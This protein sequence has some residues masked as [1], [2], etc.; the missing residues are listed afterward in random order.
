VEDLRVTSPPGSGPA[1]QMPPRGKAPLV[2]GGV[3][4]AMAVV[5]AL[6]VLGPDGGG[7]ASGDTDR[8]S[9]AGAQENE[10]GPED[11]VRRYVGAD[12]CQSLADATTQAYQAEYVELSG[13]RST[14]DFV[15]LC[16]QAREG[17]STIAQPGEVGTVEVVTQGRETA[18]VQ[19]TFLV[20]GE[21]TSLELPLRIEGGRWRVDA[22]GIDSE[23][24][25]TEP[26]GSAPS[27]PV[28][29]N[30]RALVDAFL[31]A[32]NGGDADAAAAMV[33]PNAGEGIPSGITD[34]V[35]GDASLEIDET[36]ATESSVS[37]GADL[38]GTV[39][40]QPVDF[41]RASAL[42]DA[43]DW[44]ILTFSA[45]TLGEPAPSG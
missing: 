8:R 20:Q 3:L 12:S 19:A 24:T 21:E 4:V 22:L 31:A 28:V 5:G 16:E 32:V 34:A 15:A 36:T 45:M 1:T 29:E 10:D 42:L 30:G 14:G 6:V 27:A 25:A 9:G 41:G 23:S 40:G 17:G 43:G 26:A 2:A 37:F 7:D 39:N 18:T 11:G 38:T 35:A 13:G 44:C 33:C